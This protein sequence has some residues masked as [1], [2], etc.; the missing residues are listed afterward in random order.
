MH[1]AADALFIRFID[2]TK[3]FELII[4]YG[5]SKLIFTAE[6]DRI[7]SSVK[8]G[9]RSFSFQLSF[10]CSSIATEGICLRTRS[11]NRLSILARL[12]IAN[13]KVHEDQRLFAD[14]P[15]VATHNQQ[16]LQSLNDGPLLYCIVLYCIVL[17]RIA[18][19]R[20]VLSCIVL[21]CIVLY[22]IVLYCIVLYCIVRHRNTAGHHHRRLRIR[23]RCCVPVHIP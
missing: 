17:Y 14:G 9:M 7:R 18:L 10:L 4:R 22:C 8:Q 19:Y 5:L 15:A 23:I 11:Y 12:R 2:L 13:T 1:R 3:A 20:I 16:E 6:H 21:Y